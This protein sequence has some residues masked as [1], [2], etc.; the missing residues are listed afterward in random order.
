MIILLAA[1][2][3]SATE[4]ARY[5]DCTGRA[6]TDPVAAIEA[7]SAWRADGGGVPARH[8]LGLALAANGQSAAAAETLVAAARAAEAER[9]PLTAELW[10]QAGIAALLAGQPAQ[11]HA[12]L[13][14]AL[15]AAGNAGPR[16]GAILVDRARAA[17]EL[18]RPAEAR[19]DL[20]R[21]VHL[22]P[23]D[24][25][26]W[27]L[28]AT[29]ARRQGDLPEAERLSLGAAERAPAEADV[30]AEAGNIAAAQGKDD[31]ARQAWTAAIATDAGS[32]AGKAAAA[33]LKALDATRS[34]G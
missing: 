22:A 20:A 23:D 1:A 12:H 17:V 24:P 15:V 33:A 19:A 26:A 8:C 25:E 16:S 11:A 10:A 29:L 7:A 31:L 34:G 9:L 32:P 14:T 3:L 21:A 4:A 13:S 30:Q 5:A 28:A 27:L 18:D 2:A 6:R